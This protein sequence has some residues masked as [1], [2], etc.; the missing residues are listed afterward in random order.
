MRSQLQHI[1]LTLTT[2]ALS[3]S[4]SDGFEVHPCH[5]RNLLF[6]VHRLTHPV[7][8]KK[9]TFMSYK[10]I[11]YCIF[12]QKLNVHLFFILTLQALHQRHYHPRQSAPPPPTSLAT[13]SCA[14][15]AATSSTDR[16]QLRHRRKW[17]MATVSM[18]PCPCAPQWD[19]EGR[20]TVQT[21]STF[22][23]IKFPVSCFRD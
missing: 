7:W 15:P 21:E 9:T 5:G 1:S 20:Q 14:S 12:G 3:L 4:S 18:F 13:F 19:R 22:L 10:G 16:L 8:R 11:I 23:H 2:S 6:K 17:T